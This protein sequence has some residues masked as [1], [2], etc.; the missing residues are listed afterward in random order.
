MKSQ[1]SQNQS[2]RFAR[3]GYRLAVVS[4]AGSRL[5]ILL[6]LPL[7]ASAFAQLPTPIIDVGLNDGGGTSVINNGSAG[8]TL[9]RATPIPYWTN[10][11]PDLVGGFSSVDFG[12][13]TG[14]YY[15]ES[16]TNYPQLAGLTK[17]T[18]SGWVNCRNNTIG[19]GGNRV[20]AWNAPN[21]HGVDLAFLADGSLRIGINQWPDATAGLTNIS[22][23]GRITTDPDAGAAN[24]RFFAV[25]YDST[26]PTEHLKFYFGSNADAATLDVATNYFRGAVGTGIRPFVIGHFNNT[27]RPG[28]LN[29][30]FRG[31]IDEVKVFGEALTPAQ[32]VTVQRGDGIPKPAGFVL[33]P[34]SRTVLE[35]Q[36]VT[37]SVAVTGAPPLSVQWQRNSNDIAGA[38]SPTYSLPAASVSDNGAAFRAVVSN[39]FGQAFSSNAILTV[40]TDAVAPTVVN[41]ATPRSARNLTNLTV[42]FSEPVDLGS[43]QDPGNYVL[44]GGSLLTLNAVL[45]PDLTSVLLTVDPITPEAMHT[46]TISGVS[47]RAGVPNL[48]NETNWTFFGPPTRIPA[49]VELRFDEG[50]GTTTTNTGLLGG[51]ATFVQQTAFPVFSANV[52]TGAFAPAASVASVDFGDIAAGEGGRAIDLTTAS[53]PSGT[54][55]AMSAFTISGWVN[56]R[57]LN[58][59][60]GGN[61]IA[62]ALASGNGPGFDLVQLAS[63]ALRIGVNQWPDGAGGGG[64]MSTAG[65]ITADSGAGAANWVFF[66]VTYDSSVNGGE[67]RYYFGKPDE[68]ATL[69][70]A[71]PYSRGPIVTSGRLTAGNFSTVDTPA[72]TGLGPN[73]QSRV[74]RGLIDELQVF[75]DVFSLEQIQQTQLGSAPR[76]TLAARRDGNDVVISWESP[77]NFQLQFRGDAAQG[78]WENESTLPDVNGNVRAVRVPLTATNRF[79]RLRSP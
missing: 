5:A 32:I 39:A 52:P 12:T 56:A 33:E 26:L 9:V 68:A 27:T 11:V 62:F 3:C 43:A 78:V 49:I 59:G 76:P 54:V 79:Y 55:G 47:D 75:D 30:M 61:R 10:N 19:A 50:A 7:A 2:S 17:F 45:Q 65:K 13:T 31:L 71:L 25:T 4:T 6:A 74:F 72:R 28:A 14:N 63:G 60:F 77:A 36:S 15:I 51:S 46:L 29:R 41:V 73:G 34:V 66:A 67:I 23:A 57:N 48:M 38:T 64:P 42:T 70:V 37:F 18:I 69:D 16:P 53:G 24:W 1:S 22:S 20:V 44:N 8:G 40:I 21:S 35:G 58:E